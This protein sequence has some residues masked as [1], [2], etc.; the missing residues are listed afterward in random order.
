SEASIAPSAHR[1]GELVGNVPIDSVRE[2]HR[3]ART[4]W[5]SADRAAEVLGLLDRVE[6]RATDLGQLM[7]AIMLERFGRRGLVVV[8][9]RLPAFRAEART[10]IDRYLARASELEAAARRAGER[11]E[12]ETGRHPLAGASLE[13]FVF[14][15]EDGVRHKVASSEAEQ[16]PVL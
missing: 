14:A 6:G 13:S 10:I 9:L 7:T 16:A 2:A 11:L 4:A 15:V 8:H 5:R 1:D 3:V 12:R